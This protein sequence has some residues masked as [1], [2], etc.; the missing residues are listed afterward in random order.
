MRPSLILATF[1]TSVAAA[2][3]GPVATAHAAE[4]AQETIAGLQASGYTVNVDRVGSRPIDECVVTGVR[5][6]Q[7]VTRYVREYDGRGP[8]GRA[9]YD[10]VPVITSK[11]ISVSL[12]CS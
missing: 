1:A 11:S 5:N 3:L 10:L 8:D 2:L 7:T 4:S 12:N 9:D 6:P